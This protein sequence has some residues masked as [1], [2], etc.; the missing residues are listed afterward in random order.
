MN[1]LS[2]IA[3]ALR[4]PLSLLLSEPPC[5]R[6]SDTGTPPPDWFERHA[7]AHTAIIVTDARSPDT[8]DA[9]AAAQLKGFDLRSPD[10]I[11][12]AQAVTQ[13]V[14]A[15]EQGSLARFDWADAL[16]G[17]LAAAAMLV[18]IGGSTLLFTRGHRRQRVQA[19]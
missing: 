15:T 3:R 19:T 18:V 5:P 7:K 2:R 10:T 14:E 17:A 16:V 13:P 8:R 11:D 12:A 1:H 4:E 9:A 6:A